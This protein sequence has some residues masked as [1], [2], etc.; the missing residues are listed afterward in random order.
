M[1]KHSTYACITDQGFRYWKSGDGAEDRLLLR[2]VFCKSPTETNRGR[3]WRS[4]SETAAAAPM[5][6]VNRGPLPRRRSAITKII[7]FPGDQNQRLGF[8]Q[9]KRKQASVL[10]HFPFRPDHSQGESIPCLSPSP[11][12]TNPRTPFSVSNF[13]SP[14]QLWNRVA[15]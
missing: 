7:L 8:L 9:S 12:T 15:H 4:S 14:L 3:Q 10:L 11:A 2:F 1:G 6:A 5:I 13:Q